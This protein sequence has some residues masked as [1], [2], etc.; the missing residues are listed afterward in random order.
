[1]Q[2]CEEEQDFV[3][4][5]EMFSRVRAAR[6]QTRYCPCR[7]SLESVR[8]CVDHCLNHDRSTPYRSDAAEIAK[9]HAVCRVKEGTSVLWFSRVFQKSG[10]RGNRMLLFFRE[11]YQTHWQTGSHRLK[12]YFGT[13]C[14][15]PVIPY[16]GLKF[17]FIQSLRTSNV[18]L[19]IRYRDASRK[20]HRIRAEFWRRLDW[21][22][23]H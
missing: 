3:G 23:G 5:D 8:A 19:Q 16:L 17:F 12:K 11:T 1:M 9:K 2:P 13:P 4:N 10:G 18:V 22:L 15:G 20:I 6:S 7:K 14:D 21:R